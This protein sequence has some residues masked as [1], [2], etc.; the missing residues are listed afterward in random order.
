[1]SNKQAYEMAKE[2]YA[3]YGIDTDKAIEKVSK[4]AISMHCWQGD[5]VGGFEN[6][7]GDLTGGIQVTG[8]YPGK[9]RNLAE[10]RQDFDKAASLIPG[11]KRINLHAIYLDAEGE[12]VSREKIQPKHFDSWIEWAKERDY[13][14]DYN[15][16]CFSHPM[17]ADG[18]T[19]SHPDKAVRDFWIEHCIGSRKI[20]AYIGEKLN[21]TV[22]T[23]FWMPDG[24]KDIPADKY[25]TRLRM[26]EAYDEIFKEKIDKKFNKD[27]IES[28]VFGIGAESCT[29]GSGEFCLG[30]AAK[31]DKLLTL[32]TGHFHPTEVVSDKI[33]STLLF[34]D[35]ILLHV[36][37]PVRWDSDHVVILDDELKAIASEILRGDFTDRVHIGL[38][39]FDGSINR[40][41]AWVIGTRAMQKALL[42]AALEPSAQLKMLEEKFDYTS[43]LAM[44]E[45]L[46]TLPFSAV[47]DMYCEM[48]GVPVRANWLREVK[49]YEAEVLS[50]R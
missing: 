40:I 9:A 25:G 43:R 28:K 1:M 10:L 16:T 7:D 12:K 3:E 46:K 33:S 8:N 15:P 36:S 35:E 30:Y 14:I 4:I 47:W 22:I 2:L 37:R 39:F 21:N 13:G 26:K 32:D 5:D 38:D 23:N 18:L 45:E 31:N 34:L 6:P 29:I 20:A 27:A 42:Y 17:S 50:A 44:M 11:K 41:A 24:Y 49:K 19:I 48:Q